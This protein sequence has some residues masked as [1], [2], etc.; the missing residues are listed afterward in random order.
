MKQAEKLISRSEVKFFI[1][2]ITL[3]IPVVV[4]GTNVQSQV[5]ALDEEVHEDGGRMRSD[6]E[7]MIED[8]RIIRESQIR[9]EEQLNNIL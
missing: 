9:M 5:N 7:L 8:I 6:I 4:W 3:I 2:L 1:F